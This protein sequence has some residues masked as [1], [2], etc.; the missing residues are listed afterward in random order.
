MSVLNK[1]MS[2]KVVKKNVFVETPME[3]INTGCLVL[4]I[5]FSGRLDGGIPKKKISQIVAPSSLGKSMIALRVAKYAQMM[6]MEVFFIDTEFAYNEKTALKMKI[7]LDKLGVIQSNSIEEIQ[8]SLTASINELTQAE[9][10][11][12]LIILDSWGG[13]VT[14]KTIDDAISGN[15]VSDMTVSK[16]KNALARI[17]TG[18]QCTTFVVNQTYENI[19]DKYNPLAVGGGK[20]LRFASTS[21]VMGSSKAKSKD[22][23][24]DG[25]TLGSIITASTEKSRLC[26]ERSKLKFLNEYSGGIHPYYGILEDALEG[27]FV[28]APTQGF[29]TRPTVDGDKKWREKQIWE[30]SDEFWLPIINKTGFAEYIKNKYTFDASELSELATLDIKHILNKDDIFDEEDVE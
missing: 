8:Q 28:T 16:K 14:S 3:Y 19:M 17:I 7:D 18:L 11:T 24:D 13:L 30:N 20:G 15:D 4:N 21:I 9:K 27:G 10:D 5:L 12:I 2:N 23:D 22:T 25:N 29:Y 1:I 6:G 26:K